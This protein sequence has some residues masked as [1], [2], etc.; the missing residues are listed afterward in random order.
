[1]EALEHHISLT[2]D[3]SAGVFDKE[4]KESL[5]RFVHSQKDKKIVDWV[6]DTYTEKQAVCMDF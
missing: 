3:P 1:M 6:E 2:H 4:T 5:G